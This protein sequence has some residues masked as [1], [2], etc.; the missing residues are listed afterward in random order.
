MTITL[1]GE[2]LE[3]VQQQVACGRYPSE[4]AV[5]EAGLRRLRRVDDCNDDP[6]DWI[7]H[8]AI[9]YARRETEGKE[10]PT[11]EEVLEITSKIPGSMAEEVSLQRQERY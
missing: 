2:I 10:I 7:D 3:F 4:Q 1:T 6:D 11:L 5:V 9:E 8:D